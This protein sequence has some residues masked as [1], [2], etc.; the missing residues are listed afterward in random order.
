M[1]LNKQQLEI[2]NSIDGSYLVTAVPGSGK[3]RCVT[4]RTKNMLQKGIDPSDILTV[5]FTNKATNEM[6]RRI[7]EAVSPDISGKITI[8][9]FH[10]LCARMLRAHA[11]LV[12]YTDQF[13]I[14]D[15][16]DA[17]RIQRRAIAAVEGED[18]KAGDKY[19]DA[20]RG[21]VEFRR[22][23]LATHERAALRY[24]IHGSMLDVVREYF[25]QLKKLNTIDYTGLLFEAMKL[26]RQHE[27]VRD[28]YRQRFKYISVDEVQ[29]TNV[30]QYEIIKLLGL[31]H[32]NVMVVG[33]LDQC[34]P[35]DALVEMANGS[36]KEIANIQ[37]GDKIA[38]GIGRGRVG[39]GNV[40]RISSR[41]F[42]GKL[43]RIETESGKA[44]TSTPN[45][46][47]F[48]MVPPMPDKYFV[49]LMYKK[50]KGY[51]IGRAKGARFA[52]KDGELQVGLKV[53]ANQE[54]A[55]KMWILEICDSLADAAMMESYLSAKYGIP[56]VCFHC[57]GRSLALDQQR[58]DSLYASLDTAASAQKLFDDLE[59]NLDYPHLF[60]A[61]NEATG[62][63]VV[64][65]TLF[66]A[67]KNPFDKHM[68]SLN[69]TSKEAREAIEAA[70]LKTED[71]K[72]GMW[73]LRQQGSLEQLLATAD[74][75][76]RVLP[77]VFIRR[78]ARIASRDGNAGIPLEMPASHFHPGMLIAV[79]DGTDVK[80]EMVAKV[81]SKEYDGLVHDIKVDSFHNYMSGGVV[82]HNSI[83]RFRNAEPE[84][85]LQFEKDFGAKVLKL[86]LNYR[87]TP[88]IL[89]YSQ[90][91]IERNALRKATVLKTENPS[92]ALPLVSGHQTDDEMAEHIAASVETKLREGH[93]PSEIAILYRANHASRILENKLRDRRIQY[94]IVGDLSFFNRKEI[95]A[96]I[97]ILK[98]LCNDNDHIA[99][100]KSV[101]FCC[102]GV[103]PK[104]IQLVVDAATSNKISIMEAAKRFAAA[105]NATARNLSPL[106][107][108]Y[109]PGAP[110]WEALVSIAQ[111]TAF[112][113]RMSAE[114]T[115]KNDRCANIEEMATDVRVFSE[116][117]GSLVMYLE[118][119]ALLT[120][121]K[122]DDAELEKIRMLTLHGAKGLE[123]DAVYISHCNQE[124]IPHKNCL[125]VDNPAERNRQIEE[126][127]RL[128]YVGMTRAR[129]SLTLAF[130]RS[131]ISAAGGKETFPSQFLIESGLPVPNVPC[132]K[133]LMKPQA[134]YP[135]KK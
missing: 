71:S 121:E 78:R 106:V 95:K 110:A 40:A 64:D 102:R 11:P 9:T 86:E 48:G 4:E 43:L 39:T 41:P 115:D 89:R 133:N 118:N 93:K 28:A 51:R 90:R 61:S 58:I 81:T 1:N 114:S 46:I 16:D 122:D 104:T 124:M 107:D 44:F 8:S 21:Y 17:E 22:N 75:I 60:R 108:A 92:G 99:F 83:Y 116:K 66:A 96:C 57:I 45:H 29:D 69:A 73:R 109:D 6:R 23:A 77:D 36:R 13:V 15:E 87:S 105:G 68:L 37:E 26:L 30:C 59:I 2:V 25:A 84:N 54:H 79:M 3:T 19:K 94:K 70:G 7:T 129:K 97:A 50:S 76:K 80:M 85:I 20:I 14:C 47:L 24:E 117:G 63:V 12:G 103:G 111:A 113:D 135:R 134:K 119:L 127:R 67:T 34:L 5:T 120:E 101:E 62:R 100:E 31:G 32:K 35:S 49:Y 126:E 53:R 132:P 38:C 65:I 112:W 55:D 82:C 10:S 130:C 27:N 72:R 56:T 123:F 74:V 91:L 42:C 128:M 88:E 98:L 125:A 131:V 33:D 18:F 52:E